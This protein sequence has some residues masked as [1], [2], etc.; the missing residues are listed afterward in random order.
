MFK[1]TAEVERGLI[2]CGITG[3]LALF[4]L[5]AARRSAPG[6]VRELPLAELRGLVQIV[7]VGAVLAFL[8]HGTRWLAVPVLAGMLL[9]AADIV[10]RRAKRIPRPYSVI[11]AS[12]LCG[13][14]GVLTLTTA[15]G[16]IPLSVQ[17]LIPVG[18]MVI[19]NTMNTL[20]LFLDRLHGEVTAHTG[21]IEAALAL[22]ATAETALQPG[23]SAAYR[24]CLIPSIDNIRSLGIVWIPGIMAGMVLSG[25]SP[26][27]AALYQFV[28]LTTIFAAA[29]LTCLVAHRL[30]PRRLFNSHEQ[31][32]L[33]A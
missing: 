29:A 28:V 14:G 8:L 32:L 13:A 11:L 19:A 23:L 21:E 4:V 27:Y 31:L 24:A 30:V 6:L 18:S 20:S 1:L 15:S 5:L 16:V 26:L 33:R 9:A 17:I 10:R 25:T 2:D 12:M 7:A 3:L 22:G